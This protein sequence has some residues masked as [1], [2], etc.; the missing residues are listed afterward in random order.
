MRCPCRVAGDELTYAQCCQ[1]L[2]G[3]MR[4]APTAEALMRSR[5]SAYAMRNAPYLLATW[6]SSTRPV[7]MDFPAAQEWQH[8]RIV[9]AHE[10]GNSATVEFVARSRIAGRKHELHEISR[11]V[12]VFGRW[13]YVDGLIK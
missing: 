1:A 7:T 10:Q 9:A 12:R 4:P 6:H 11:F 2:H 8:L 3:G 5:Y 13:F